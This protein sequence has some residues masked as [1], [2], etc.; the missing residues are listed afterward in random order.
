M[1]LPPELG[2]SCSPLAGIYRRARP[3][4]IEILN[5]L[6]MLNIQ[7]ELVGPIHVFFITKSHWNEL[8]FDV[9]ILGLIAET[10]FPYQI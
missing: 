10:L 7:V 3:A 5:N 1:I 4:D 9:Q 6:S 8:L 2:N